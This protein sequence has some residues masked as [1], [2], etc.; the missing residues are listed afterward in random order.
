MRK[1]KIIATLGP[2]SSSP[3]MISGLH[4][5]GVSVFRLNCSHINT[6]DLAGAVRDVRKNAPRAAVLVDIRGPKMRYGGPDR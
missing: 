2:K 6:A 3:Q 1:T 4:K 5:V